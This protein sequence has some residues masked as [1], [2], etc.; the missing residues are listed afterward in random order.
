VT[1]AIRSTPRNEETGA[2]QFLDTGKDWKISA[3]SPLW[4]AAVECITH[5][6]TA[7]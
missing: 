7:G 4:S 2:V 5:L 6:T 3:A 1:G